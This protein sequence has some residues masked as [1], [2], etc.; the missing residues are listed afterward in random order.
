LSGS[1]TLFRFDALGKPFKDGDPLASAASS[2]ERTEINITGDGSTRKVTV[3]PET[4]YV[5]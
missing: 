2:F 5:Y 1:G 4:G 3:E